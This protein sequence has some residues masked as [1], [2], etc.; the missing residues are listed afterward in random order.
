[1][2]R[3]CLRIEC[4][5]ST[6]VTAFELRWMT[7]RSKTMSLVKVALRSAELQLPQVLSSQTRPRR[8]A[9]RKRWA[10]GA[11]CNWNRCEISWGLESLDD[12]SSIGH[13]I[14]LFA[15]RAGNS[16][17]RL[18]P[19]ESCPSTFRCNWKSP[20]SYGQFHRR[21]DGFRIPYP[22]RHRPV[23]VIIIPARNTVGPRLQIQ[24]VGI[25][26]T[27]LFFRVTAGLIHLELF[28]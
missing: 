5:A 21:S 7:P 18:G 10:I 8:N 25:D 17:Y 22:T 27:C 2:C 1:M 24:L 14:Y 26:E 6:R 15:G 20:V 13:R 19:G 23:G 3:G 28:D 12:A 11:T 16:E 9:P 4:P